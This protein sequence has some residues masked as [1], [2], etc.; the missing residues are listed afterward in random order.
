MKKTLNRFYHAN[1]LA[2]AA[3][4]C[5]SIVLSG[6]TNSEKKEKSTEARADSTAEVREVISFEGV[7]VTGLSV[8]DKGRIFANFPRWREGV[9]FSVVEVNEA[10]GSYDVYPNKTFNSW[11]IGETP[12][13]SAFVGVQSVVVH[14]DML[15]V[16]DTRNPLFQGIIEEPRV[17]VFDLNND[18]LAQIYVIDSSAVKPK[19]YVNDLRVDEKRNKIYLTDSG[20]AGLIIINMQNGNVSRVLDNHPSTMAETDHLTIDGKRWENKTHSDGIALDSKNNR[21]YYHALTGYSLYY[22]DTEVLDGSDT[23]I[24]SAVK[25]VRKTSAPDGMILDD[26]GN[27]YYADLENHKINYLTPAGEVKT[28][29]EGEEVRWADTF[30]IYDG[31]LYYTN[32]RIHEASGDVS[33]MQFPIQKV[34]LPEA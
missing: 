6:C 4:V 25:F 33:G 2:L 20:E 19:S 13:D 24:Q 3:L 31:F 14:K 23:A 17:Y 28:L 12:R 9:P 7:Q 8:S 11:T 21:L 32:S 22:V 26:A 16:L 18:E 10:D 30:S 5:I 34:S 29:V 27:L 15:Y 1:I